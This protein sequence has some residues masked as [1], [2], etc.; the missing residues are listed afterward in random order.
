MDQLWACN[1][2]DLS[3]FFSQSTVFPQQSSA[4]PPNAEASIGRDGVR[5]SPRLCCHHKGVGKSLAIYD[6]VTLNPQHFLTE[7]MPFWTRCITRVRTRYSN[8]RCTGLSVIVLL[9]LM[10]TVFFL[11]P[12]QMAKIAPK[13][14]GLHK[15][16]L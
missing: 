9:L 2:L 14:Y 11:T 13:A 12:Q 15:T 3:V 10:S 6:N 7:V 4:L 16:P 5:S 8:L 1:A